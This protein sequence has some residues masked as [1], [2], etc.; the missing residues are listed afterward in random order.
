MDILYENMNDKVSLI[1]L[2]ESN[3]IIR[4]QIQQ[5]N[6]QMIDKLDSKQIDMVHSKINQFDSIHQNL[7]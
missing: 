4:I 5:L 1:Q 6:R 7:S 2:E 3:D